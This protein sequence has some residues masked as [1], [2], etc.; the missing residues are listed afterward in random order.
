[1]SSHTGCERFVRGTSCGGIGVGD[2]V[3]EAT[4]G[5]DGVVAVETEYGRDSGALDG[6]GRWG[7]WLAGN[8]GRGDDFIATVVT[9]IDRARGGRAFEEDVEA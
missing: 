4:G 8:G 7:V 2:E 5:A 6:T 3:E 9:G 1:M